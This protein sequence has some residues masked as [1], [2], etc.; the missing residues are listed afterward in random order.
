MLNYRDVIFSWL[1]LS[2][3]ELFPD[4]YTAKTDIGTPP[5]FPATAIVQKNTINYQKTR[6]SC[7]ENHVQN[8]YQVDIYTNGK[9]TKE[10]EAWSIAEAVYDLMLSKGFNCTMCEPTPN[11]ADMSIYRITMRFEGV[12]GR[13]GLVYSR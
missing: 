10:D 1:S 3:M 9:K 5:K 7:M 13:N 4:I 6:D 12:I 11:L 8:M 2:L